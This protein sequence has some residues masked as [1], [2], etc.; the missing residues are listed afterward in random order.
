MHL[1][2]YVTFGDKIFRKDIYKFYL[3]SG[4]RFSL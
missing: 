4:L 2:H 1:I 3:F